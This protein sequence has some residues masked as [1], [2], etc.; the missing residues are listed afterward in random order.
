[1]LPDQVQR[2]HLLYPLVQN[3][4]FA[5]TFFIPAGPEVGFKQKLQLAILEAGVGG[6]V[7]ACSLAV[8]VVFRLERGWSVEHSKFCLALPAYV[9]LEVCCC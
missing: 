3:P 7:S 1:M 4:Q 6:L 8:F 2:V 5:H 9:Y